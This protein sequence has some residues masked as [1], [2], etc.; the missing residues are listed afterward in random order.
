[1]GFKTKI[2][3]IRRQNSQQW[4]VNFPSACAQMMDFRKGEV[5]EWV[6]TEQGDLLLRRCSLSPRRKGV[7]R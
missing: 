4:Y 7:E 6:L 3:L 1:M 5:M 2:Q